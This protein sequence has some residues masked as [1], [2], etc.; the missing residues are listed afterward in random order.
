[1]ATDKKILLVIYLVTL[2]SRFYQL[3]NSIVY[4]DEVTWMV[5]GKETI[6]ALAKL[7]I[8]YF[9][10]AW[11][12][13][14]TETYAIGLPVVVLNGLFLF[15]NGLFMLVVPS[16]WYHFVPGLTGRKKGISP[17]VDSVA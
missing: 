7:N 8:S 15:G 14:N 12:N 17:I 4:P 16:P 1:M 11:W 10:T 5:K 3:N 2:F 13:D 9:K 6:Y